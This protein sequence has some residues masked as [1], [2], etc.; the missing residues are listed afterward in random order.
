LATLNRRIGPISKRLA[1]IDALRGIAAMVVVL[2][3]AVETAFSHAPADSALRNFVRLA[4]L[5]DFNIGRVGVVAFFCISGFVVP[6]SFAGPAPLR[7]FVVSRFFRLYPAYWLSILCAVGVYY[8]CGGGGYSSF[9]VAANATM[10]QKM[11][12]QPDMIGVY[13]TLLIELIFYAL[14][15]TAFACRV[16]SSPL[17]LFA[18]LL[19]LLTIAVVQSLL[20]LVSHHVGGSGSIPFFLAVMILGT[21]LRLRALESNGSAGPLAGLALVAIVVTAPLIAYC[22]QSSDTTGAG[23]IAQFTGCYAGLLLFLVCIGRQAFAGRITLLLG[24][25]S[26]ALY[27]FHTLVGA[28]LDRMLG[29]MAFP[30]SAVAFLP[31]MI[32]LSVAVAAGVHWLIER[33]GIATG[34][35][36]NRAMTGNAKAI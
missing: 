18:G 23:W 16:L 20:H 15:F 9:A 32:L 6:F 25:I 26:Y 8:A 2:Q 27:L 31:L 33:P 19:L 4:F 36:I 22:G 28:C 1:Y 21:L 34:R 17:H 30:W 3:H 35:A 5:D 11:L 13:W 29:G 24:S 10:V 7:A 12:H 14:C